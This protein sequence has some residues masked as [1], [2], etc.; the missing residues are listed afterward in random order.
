MFEIDDLLKRM[1]MIRRVRGMTQVDL[2][3]CLNVSY[4]TYM[5]LI[6]RADDFRPS[7][8]TLNKMMVFIKEW[9]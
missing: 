2:A 6:G 9:E 4:V 5:R 1:E 8:K 7:M 3:R